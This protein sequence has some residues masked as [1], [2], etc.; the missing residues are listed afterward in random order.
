VGSEGG[1]GD[2]RGRCACAT[3]WTDVV[4]VGSE[5][6]CDVVENCEE[7]GGEGRNAGA[8]DREDSGEGNDWERGVTTWADVGKAG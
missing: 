5:G 4:K 2:K 3:T 6:E 7:M 1:E 8:V